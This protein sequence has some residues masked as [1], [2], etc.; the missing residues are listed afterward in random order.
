M[1]FLY[2]ITNKYILAILVQISTKEKHYFCSSMSRLIAFD[3]AMLFSEFSYLN[4]FHR[5]FNAIYIFTVIIAN[6]ISGRQI[7]IVNDYTYYC[8]KVNLHTIAWR[9]TRGNVCK[10]RFITDMFM[11]IVKRSQ[12][13]HTHKS[14]PYYLRDGCYYRA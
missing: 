9:C 8:A 2:Y 11:N 7:A 13:N 1:L 10:A 6:N 5:I 4:L 14:S 12:L 3:C